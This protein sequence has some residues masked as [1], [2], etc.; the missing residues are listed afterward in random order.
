MDK[1]QTIINESNTSSTSGA[2]SCH[3]LRSVEGSQPVPWWHVQWTRGLWTTKYSQTH[4]PNAKMAGNKIILN[5]QCESIMIDVNNTESA[6]PSYKPSECTLP[7]SHFDLLHC[8]FMGISRRCSC[9]WWRSRWRVTWS[10]CGW[11]SGSIISPFSFL[12]RTHTESSFQFRVS[13]LWIGRILSQRR[14]FGIGRILFPHFMN[15]QRSAD[16]YKS[17]VQHTH[18]NNIYIF[19]F[20]GTTTLSDT[21]WIK[22]CLLISCKLVHWQVPSNS[23]KT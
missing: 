8:R 17:N 4:I 19:R 14:H 15:V 7:L 16:V 20:Q 12:C 13:T 21:V 23:T 3:P 22:K 18:P 11:C 9:R 6:E 10:R 5:I 2:S 1:R